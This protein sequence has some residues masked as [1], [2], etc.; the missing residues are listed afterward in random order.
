[1]VGGETRREPSRGSRVPGAQHH[2]IW[3][4]GRSADQVA[5]LAQRRPDRQYGQSL[6]DMPTSGDPTIVTPVENPNNP[7][8][9]EDTLIL[10]VNPAAR[11]KE[12]SL[13]AVADNG[14][15]T[16]AHTERY[17]NRPTN[18]ANLATDPE[19]PATTVEQRGTKI[20]VPEVRLKESLVS[21]EVA[22]DLS[23]MSTQ[24][25]QQL[26]IDYVR[27]ANEMAKYLKNGGDVTTL[28]NLSTYFTTDRGL[29]KRCA[30]LVQ[31]SEMPS[32]S[33]L[34]ELMQEN[35]DWH[36]AAAREIGNILKG[37]KQQS[38][39]RAAA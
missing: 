37:R 12:A 10:A 18:L 34:T 16:N 17:K 32:R 27:F 26:E 7:L 19:L 36:N 6:A 24:R 38:G 31:H 3:N 8:G 14:R 15:P 1:M 20:L 35:T 29:Q 21:P 2:D 22:R 11:P 25:L 30:D 33:A 23:A 4:T 5:R 39:S 13:T 9:S 28:E